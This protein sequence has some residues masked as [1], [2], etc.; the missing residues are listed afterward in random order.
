MFSFQIIFSAVDSS[1]SV[2]GKQ[3]LDTR[4]CCRRR[5]GGWRREN[6]FHE[7]KKI[8]QIE[9]M[10]KE[11]F[12]CKLR[13]SP[14]G[15]QELKTNSPACWLWR[16]LFSI[17]RLS[18]TQRLLGFVADKHCSPNNVF[19][20]HSRL[21]PAKPPVTAFPPPPSTRSWFRWKRNQSRCWLCF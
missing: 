11:K 20:I 14:G 10:I 12:L 4:H 17:C 18:R 9:I 15:R 21:S 8:F 19:F 16:N 3:W 13:P 6:K 7:R 5:V 2:F 1:S